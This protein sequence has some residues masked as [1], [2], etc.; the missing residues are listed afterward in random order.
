MAKVFEKQPREVV[1][2]DIEGG[3]YFDGID[4]EW[5]TVIL[6]IDNVTVPPLEFGP[7]DL[8][9]YELIGTP[10]HDVKIWV[11]GGKD[12]EKYKITALMTSVA[13]R[14][15]EKEFFVKVKET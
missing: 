7:G 5:D 1:D 3:D 2:Y 12:G 10:P 9:E 11:F 13:E 15:E 8:S 14:V 4:D 6:E